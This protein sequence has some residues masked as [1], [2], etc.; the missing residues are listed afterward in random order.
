MPHNPL[1][2]LGVA[3]SDIGGGAERIAVDL[4]LNLRSNG[5]DSRLTVGSDR[6]HTPFTYEINNS[7]YRSGPIQFI[8]RIGPSKERATEHRVPRAVR[9]GLHAVAQPQRAF[10]RFV[11]LDDFSYPATAHLDQIAGFDPSILHLHNLHGGYFDLRMLSRLSDKWPTVITAHDTWLKGG[12]CTYSME[13]TSWLDGCERCSH[14]DYPPAIRFDVARQNWQLKRRILQ[15]S[16]INLVTS[17]QWAMDQLSRS[18]VA[19]AIVSMRIIPYGIDLSVFKPACKQSIREQLDLDQDADI[20]LFAATSRHNPYKDFST[21]EQSM[22]LIAEKVRKRK[23]LLLF[24]GGDSSLD[25]DSPQLQVRGI[26]FDSNPKNVAQWYQASDLYLHAAKA[27]LFGLVTVEAQACG[28]P[29]VVTA[30]DGTPESLIDGETGLLVEKENP[31]SM[32]DAVITLL[33]NQERRL[34]MGDAGVSFVREN[35]DSNLMTDRYLEFY[36]KILHDLDKN[37]SRDGAL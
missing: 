36:R 20:L 16:R 10:R 4:H 32:A 12:H 1:R 18:I 13:C 17:T 5:I 22:R 23:L 15:E 9:R 21:I 28:T 27:E 33:D 8:E 34:S 3:P 26:P 30:V 7:A 19:D 31:R 25:K 6:G 37:H 29:V 2:I 24:L 11:G 14:L 35:F